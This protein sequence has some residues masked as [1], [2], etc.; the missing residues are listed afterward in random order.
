M[1]PT[2]APRQARLALLAGAA[3]FGTGG[4]AVKLSTLPAWAIVAGRAGIAALFLCAASREARRLGRGSVW[5]V[6]SAYAAT[7]VLFVLAN[8]ETTAAS[9]VFLQSTAPLYALGLGFVLL[10]ERPTRADGWTMALLALALVLLLA[11][12]GEP[13]ASAPSPAL[14]N[15]LAAC[16]GVTWGLTLTG[17]RRLAQR[18]EPTLGAVCAGNLLACALGG[19]VLLWGPAWSAEASRADLFVLG[20]LGI[21]QIGLAYMLVSAGL[22][23]TPVFQASLLLL[24]E[25]VLSVLCAWLVHG[26]VPSGWALVGGAL[27][28]GTC[29]QRALQGPGRARRNRAQST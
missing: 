11:R 26:E 27:V 28:L 5:L 13:Q 9:T 15:A 18:G 20:W 8:R 4:A 14:G 23:A 24:V 16:A 10:G 6:A 29:V 7:T 25:P 17:L 2:L 3:L 1:S 22:A 21:F 12:P 19:A